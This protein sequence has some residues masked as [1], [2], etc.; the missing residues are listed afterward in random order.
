LPIIQVIG[1][2]FIFSYA[3]QTGMTPNYSR[4]GK[5]T[6]AMNED[7]F[8]QGMETGKFLSPRHRAYCVLLYYS[9]VRK[10]EGLKAKREQ[11][12]I[13]QDALV[14]DVSKRLK[15]S[16][17]TPPLT[18]PLTAP[19][20]LELKEAIE[21]TDPGKRV[22]PYSPRTGYNIVRRAFK[23]PHLFRLSRITNFFLQGWTIPQVRAWTGL[24][25]RALDYYIGLVDVQKMGESLGRPAT[26]RS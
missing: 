20:M 4:E 8:K 15:G 12:Q 25:L 18:L 21:T 11:F 3:K 14:F 2:V 16:I 7:E 6:T 23:Y 10:Q 19:Y 1:K 5:I 24:S 26:I 9:A 22:F 13:T 17:T